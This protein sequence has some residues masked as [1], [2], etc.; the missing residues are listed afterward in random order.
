MYINNIVNMKVKYEAIASN[1]PHH[2]NQSKLNK[3]PNF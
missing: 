3:K 1:T 2:E